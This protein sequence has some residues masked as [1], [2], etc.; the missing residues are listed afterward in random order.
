LV[1]FSLLV[2]IVN[3]ND[4]LIVLNSIMFFISLLIISILLSFFFGNIDAYN[5]FLRFIIGLRLFGLLLFRL[6]LRFSLFLLF[7]MVLGSGSTLDLRMLL[8]LLLFF[9]SFSND[10]LFDFGSFL[11]LLLINILH[12]LVFMLIGGNFL[13]IHWFIIDNFNLIINHLLRFMLLRGNWLLVDRL[14]GML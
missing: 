12:R 2:S 13:I 14:R 3:F 1:G 6:I 8:F 10:W 9:I 5:F 7:I 4:G 11:L